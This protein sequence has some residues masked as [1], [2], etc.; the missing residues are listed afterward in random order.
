VTNGKKETPQFLSTK[1]NCEDE[2]EKEDAVLPQ[3]HEQN[4]KHEKHS[5]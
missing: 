2:Q 3:G 1:K 5:V 4:S